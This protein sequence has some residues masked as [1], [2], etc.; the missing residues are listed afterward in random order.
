MRSARGLPSEDCPSSSCNT[1]NLCPPYTNRIGRSGRRSLRP[2]D[3]NT[4]PPHISTSCECR[5][6]MNPSVYHK[7]SL[8]PSIG[9]TG[10]A[11]GHALR[12]CCAVDGCSGKLLRRAQNGL[13]Y[14]PQTEHH[15]C[16]SPRTVY[17]RQ[18]FGG[19]PCHRTRT[20]RP[21]RAIPC[22]LPWYGID[23]VRCR[24]GHT[25][26]ATTMN[27]ALQVIA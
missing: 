17:V 7:R 27:H 14:V 11:C 6:Q 22:R 5:T 9:M 8:I 21:S 20:G 2:V 15:A 4:M 19:A 18:G 1:S 12:R 3:G 23:G 13:G 26:Q 24:S 10:G 25:L 16:V